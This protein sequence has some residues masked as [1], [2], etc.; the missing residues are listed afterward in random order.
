MTSF[1]HVD[2]C[3]TLFWHFTGHLR[4]VVPCPID[5]YCYVVN[6][7]TVNLRWAQN[8]FIRSNKSRY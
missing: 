4:T 2:L 1:N 3:Q 6:A 8:A 7:Y 5:T